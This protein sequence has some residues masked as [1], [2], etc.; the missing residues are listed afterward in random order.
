M[1]AFEGLW[2]SYEEARAAD[3]P[4]RGGQSTMNYVVGHFN[5]VLDRVLGHSGPFQ[6]CTAT[7]CA[8]PSRLGDQS[9][10]PKGGAGVAYQSADD[11]VA[12]LR[13]S[14]MGQDAAVATVARRMQLAAMGLA[15]KPERPLGVFLFVGPSGCGKTELA[16]AVAEACFGSR[17]AM[18]RL[19]MS[20]YSDWH[21]AARLTGPPPGYH[22]ID[23]P[24]GWLTTKVIAQPRCVLLLD[25]M[26]KAHRDIYP[27]FLQVFDSG[28]LTDGRNQTADFSEVVVIMTSNIGSRE[29]GRTP[30]GFSASHTG[31]GASDPSTAGTG[32][33]PA[34]PVPAAT[35][36][37]V[38]AAIDKEFAPEFLNRCD[39]II[40]FGTLPGDAMRKITVREV[41]RAKARLSELGYELTVSASV[42][43]AIAATATR[44]EYGA[45]QL[46]RIVENGVIST[47]LEHKP[48]RLKAMD[49]EVDPGA[50]P[51]VRVRWKCMPQR[52]KKAAA[53]PGRPPS[54]SSL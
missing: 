46:H 1:L 33:V 39:H 6:R 2:R 4:T 48:C 52:R 42:V 51:P 28:R 29:Y 15:L 24:E 53:K 5:P 14:V 43:D 37:R 26:E 8:G 47:A 36:Q 27:Q 34:S 21:Q 50:D 44:P 30:P 45:R 23:Q 17:D 41:N 18:I 40:Q 22:G 32:R 54:A 49:V 9:E 31:A 19:D 12:E 20:E 38:S 35:V 3:Q 7:R 25:E 11:L 16:H 10:S 13:K